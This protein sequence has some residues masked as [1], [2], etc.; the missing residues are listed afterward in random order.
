MQAHTKRIVLAGGSGFVGQ[1]LAGRLLADGYEVIVLSRGGP[2]GARGT[3]VP[4]D[5]STLGDWAKSLE[6]CSAVVN[7]T[8]RNINCRPTQSNRREIVRSRVASVQAVGEAI[9]RCRRPPRV[10]VQTSAVGIYGDAGDKV[11][12]EST[13]PG[14]GFLG[15]VCQQWEKAVDETPTPGVRRVVLRLGVVLGREGGAF[16]PLARLAR[17]FLGGAVGSGRQYIS[18]LH[19]A[20]AVRIYRDAIDREDFQ[21]TYVAA[22]PQPATNAQFMRQLRAALDRPWSPPAP[23][24]AVRLGGWVAGINAELALTGQRCAPRRLMG[25]GFAYEFAELRGALKELVG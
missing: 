10:F 12:D 19:L 7:L 4:W 20:D 23:A 21:G 8:G 15:E 2:R 14:G 9:R 13:P 17:W 3:L 18:W 11:C 24:L 1:A 5:G 6:D 16:P 25:Q 22:S